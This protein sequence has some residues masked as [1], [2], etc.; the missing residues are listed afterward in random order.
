MFGLARIGRLL[1]DVDALV[2]V[3]H[4]CDPT[5]CK[6]QRCCCEDYEVVMGRTELSRIIGV[7]D[8]AGE[9]LPQ[10]RDGVDLTDFYEELDA[11]TFAI[12]TDDDMRCVFA[13]GG[14]AGETRCA[15]H[16][17]ALDLSMDPGKLKPKAC[18]LWPLGF[19]D[20]C[21]RILGVQPDAFRYP[22]TRRRREHRRPL[23]AGIEEIIASL[24][25]TRFLSTLQ[26]TILRTRPR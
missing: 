19:S 22:C 15:V 5:L 10:G 3:S 20:D 11:L 1:V 18:T 13:Y 9:Y 12:A 8:A 21:P 6:G 14:P 25:G 7:L 4:R 16:S 23:D 24:F 2:G 17:V 26:A